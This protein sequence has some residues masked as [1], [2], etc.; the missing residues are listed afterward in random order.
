MES[1]IPDYEFQLWDG[2]VAPTGTPAHIVQQLASAMKV[3]L[4]RP[5]VRQVFSRD[6]EVLSMS[7]AQFSAL[8]KSDFEKLGRAVKDAGLRVE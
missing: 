8:I 7:S 1:G 5:E 4:E 2:L 3:A 6:G